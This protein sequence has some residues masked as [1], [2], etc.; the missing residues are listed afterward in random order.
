MKRR[1]TIFGF[2]VTLGYR[3]QLNGRKYRLRSSDLTALKLLQHILHQI[4]YEARPGWL[5]PLR[6]HIRRMKQLDPRAAL[7]LV[8]ALTANE[9]VR[10]LA[11][12]LRGRCGGSLGTT[13][14]FQ[15]A[16][17][18]NWRTRK[19]V[20]QCL[21]RMSAWSQLRWIASTEVDP[22]VRRIAAVQPPREYT[23]RLA[24]YCDHVPTTEITPASTPMFIAPHDD[25]VTGR[26][27]KPKWLIRLL[28][29]R[30]QK[31]VSG[32]EIRDL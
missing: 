13:I 18:P 21:K 29:H 5:L 4:P 17:A 12:W 3:Y 23:D 24:D 25:A 2:P 9:D 1:K 7:T 15:F 10:R 31:L 6:P 22:R 30:I 26:P 14:I 8:I 19:V 32:H 11:V 27:A 16:R 28:L 20:A